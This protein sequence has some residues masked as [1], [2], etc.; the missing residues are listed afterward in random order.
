M[1]KE[2]V[3]LMIDLFMQITVIKKMAVE[4]ESVVGITNKTF[5]V[6]V[7]IVDLSMEIVKNFVLSV[8]H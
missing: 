8:L 4:A 5:K 2:K 6:R 3:I 7:M 1:V